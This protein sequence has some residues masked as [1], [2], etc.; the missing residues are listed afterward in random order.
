MTSDDH[1]GGKPDAES[2]ETPFE[3]NIIAYGVR[4]Y[5]GEPL[6]IICV[7]RGYCLLNF[8]G[9]IMSFSNEKGL[10]ALKSLWLIKNVAAGIVPQ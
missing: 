9:G 6:L 5:F 2:V 10:R 1:S 4:F 3:E 7:L 8:I